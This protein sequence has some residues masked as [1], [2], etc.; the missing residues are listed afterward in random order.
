M[1]IVCTLGVKVTFLNCF[2]GDGSLTSHLG[3]TVSGLHDIAC[4]FFQMELGASMFK[5]Y[6]LARHSCSSVNCSAPC[7]TYRARDSDEIS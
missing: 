4:Q 1:K 3:F 5:L 6:D 7:C 2:L